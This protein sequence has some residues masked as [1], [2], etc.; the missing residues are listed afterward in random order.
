MG[1]FTTVSMEFT[2]ERAIK[3][4][5]RT[6]LP[7]LDGIAKRHVLPC[8]AR[9]PERYQRAIHGRTHRSPQRHFNCRPPAHAS[10]TQPYAQT[11]RAAVAGCGR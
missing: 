8:C 7:G 3:A 1:N 6:L 5:V 9:T 10:N 4:F 11:C 2:P